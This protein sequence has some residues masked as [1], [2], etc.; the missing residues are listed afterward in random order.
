[1][2]IP[3]Q[4]FKKSRY[5]KKYKVKMIERWREKLHRL[6]RMDGVD[7]V[8]VDGNGNGNDSITNNDVRLRSSS[9]VAVN[10]NR[11]KHKRRTNTK[12]VVHGAVRNVSLALLCVCAISH[13]IRSERYT[14]NAFSLFSPESITS[15]L[16]SSSARPEQHSATTA[17]FL[18]SLKNDNNDEDDATN[19]ENDNDDERTTA[20][21]EKT[22]GWDAEEESEDFSAW[23]E[24]LKRGTPLGKMAASPSSPA[25]I[26]SE[27]DNDSV[28][29]TLDSTAATTKTPISSSSSTTTSN[30]NSVSL[31][32]SKS[33]ADSSSTTS[34]SSNSSNNNSS[35]SSSSI[36]NTGRRKINP[37]SNLIQFE[38]M[39]ELAKIAGTKDGTSDKTDSSS[40]SSATDVFAVVDRLVKTFQK[41]EEDKQKGRKELLQLAQLEKKIKTE[42]KR[43]VRD[44][45]NNNDSNSNNNSGDSIDGDTTYI[46]GVSTTT[47]VKE[48][49]ELDRYVGGLPF[50]KVNNIW[51][52]FSG[53]GGSIA[54]IDDGVSEDDT[55]NDNADGKDDSIPS[56]GLASSSPLFR[57]KE[58][59]DA[60]DVTS[61]S[62]ST[63]M[64]QAAESI[65]KDT[66]NKME[67]LVAEA[68]SAI[69]EPSDDG[70]T[71]SSSNTSTSTLQDL[72][73]RASSV[74]NNTAT[75]PSS[76]TTTAPNT[77][78]TTTG[79]IV[80]S[81]S[82]DIVS[83][84]QKIAKES[85]VEINVQFAADRAREA[86]EFAVG[87][88]ATAN[89]VLDAG[90]AYGSRS[91]SSFISTTSGDGSQVAEANRPPLFGDFASAQ[92]IENYEF[93]NVVFQGAEMG[94]LAGAIYEDPLERCHQLG[95]SLVANGTTANVAWMVTDSVMD[96]EHYT[97]AFRHHEDDALSKTG[98]G[99]EDSSEDAPSGPVM[100]RTITMRGFDA[101]D[102][103]VDREALLNEICFATAE[104]MD[105][106]TADRVVFHKGLL[107]IAREMYAEMKQYIDWTSPNHKIVL[108]GHSVGGS[109]SV[110][111]LLLIAS[112]RGGE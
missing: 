58:P 86:T 80:E 59:N 79:T 15:T 9:S 31:R 33:K 48:L 102:E 67:Y 4:Q 96:R 54:T 25:R 110:L 84:A 88:A 103:S 5:G 64:A 104:P 27:E 57:G 56:T 2:S 45:N 6:R 49:M 7:G 29:G 28:V 11:S 17:L 98:D 61:S 41:Q 47:T 73:G 55:T 92:R 34:S 82:N 87:V 90:Y 53:K 51:D 81:I 95:H 75:S 91:G 94:V 60:D 66:T 93:D 107:N 89:M 77:A 21:I 101:S 40:N 42:E 62:T 26:V 108:N 52:T 39:L 10:V 99:S 1:L 3:K 20:T 37:L 18:F 71:S 72:V 30:V 97:S 24:G 76:S 35:S 38:A 100:I 14:A 74:F 68:S 83:T 22:A 23:M 16:P 111:M 109:L 105:D 69:L 70:S 46:E 50:P 63:N 43:L 32:D 78:T 85:G 44:K 13:Q 106:T 65:L 8:D 112:E 12:T 36:E 19:T